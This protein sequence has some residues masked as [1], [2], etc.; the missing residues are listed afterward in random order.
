M[1][2]VGATT[3]TDIADH[4]IAA[5]QAGVMTAVE[6]R[7]ADDGA[8]ADYD[9]FCRTG[10]H[11]PPQHPLWVREWVAANRSDAL[12]VTVRDEDRIVSMLPL[13]VTREGP[14]R[15]ARFIGGRHANGNFVARIRHGTAKIERHAIADAVRQAR[16]DIDLMALERQNPVHEGVPNF[17]GGLAT[18]R[19][20][21]ISLAVDL[22]G[23][24][25]G[26]L[27]RKNGKRK[28]RKQKLQ[29]RKMDEAGGWRLIKAAT[30]DE[31][32]RLIEAFFTLKAARFRKK[33][34]PNTFASPEIQAFFRNLFISALDEKTPPFTLYGLE[35]AGEICGIHGFS[36]TRD[37]IVCDFGAIREDDLQI[38]PGF[39]I[40]YWAI[41]EA[42][43]E[44]RRLYD[45][46][47]GDEPYKRSWCDVETWQ[48]E[49]LLPLTIRGR[50]L[51]ALIRARSRAVRSIKSNETLWRWT[52]A[53]RTRL[54]GSDTPSPTE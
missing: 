47:V 10:I 35:V 51:L 24:F 5:P 26:V 52:R 48:F 7:A 28:R 23:G 46:S 31:V 42:C 53:I 39:F 22:E 14:F 45:L 13:E 11:A 3:R 32:D 34:I 44:G 38:S 49:T 30:P 16:P 19:S 33:G 37:S 40:D 15:V 27:S 20:P 54:A 12:I 18:T 41:E 1:V 17:L 43:E 21:N 8:L 29:I 9:T 25:E 4:S 50:V 36:V 6:V 2:D